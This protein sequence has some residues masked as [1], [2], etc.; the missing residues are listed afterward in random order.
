MVIFWV[1][2]FD[3]GFL[4]LLNPLFLRYLKI[5]IMDQWDVFAIKNATL[6]LHTPFWHFFAV[7]HQNAIFYHFHL[8]L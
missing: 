6:R 4:K 2:K 3:T 8:F 7:F 1:L 5:Y